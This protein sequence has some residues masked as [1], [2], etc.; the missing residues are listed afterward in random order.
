VGDGFQMGSLRRRLP[1]F[2]C[3]LHSLALSQKG[4]KATK[5]PLLRGG[6]YIAAHR[7]IHKCCPFFAIYVFFKEKTN[8]PTDYELV[9]SVNEQ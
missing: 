8:Y 7:D 4:E 6:M 9:S 5:A 1:V 3:K 2:L